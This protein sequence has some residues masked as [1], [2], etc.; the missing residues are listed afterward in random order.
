M[1]D[2]ETRAVTV[3]GP[4]VASNSTQTRVKRVPKR[5]FFFE[6]SKS[7]IKRW[8]PRRADAKR[9]MRRLADGGGGGWMEDDR[10][11]EY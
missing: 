9:A 4:K 3:S 5:R 6:Q 7:L 10:S 8:Q 11:E 2:G 1:L